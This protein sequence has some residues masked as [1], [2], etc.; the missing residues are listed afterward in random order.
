MKLTR[1]DF[2]K[3]NAIA[4]TAAAAGIT[5]PGLQGALAQGS[6]A[7]R[8]DKAPCRFCG[9][10][11][12]VLV[13]TKDGRV[14]ATQGDPDAPVNR[15]LNCIKGYFLS[16][17]MYGKDRLTKPLL[18]K[19]NGKYD[20][21]GE[22]VEVSWNEAFDIMA[23]KWKA[24]MKKDMEANKGKSVDELVSSVGMFGSGQWTVW[25]GYAAAKLYKAG[26]RSNHIDPNARHCMASAVVG[27]IRA[28]GSDE[29]MGC[30]DDMEHGDA[31]VLWGSNMAE[32]HPI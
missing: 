28:F 13:G 11:C 10:G 19:T 8:W 15:G 17:I 14:V 23:D 7:I 2:V 16:K 22:F 27:F 6:D 32:M 31:F 12:S 24:A 20:K 4:A 26:F 21:N 29:P 18:R 5:V 1:R 30:Y 3:T 9:T 25:E